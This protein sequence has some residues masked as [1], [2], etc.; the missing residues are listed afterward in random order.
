MAKKKDET[1]RRA[2]PD[3]VMV[4]LAPAGVKHAGE[5]GTLGWA[6][7]RRHFKFV[8]GEAQELER[9]FEW[10]HLLRP[11][12]ISGEPMFEEVP[13]EPEAADAPVDAVGDET[14]KDGE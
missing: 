6:N 1:K 10:N 5:A 3:F 2:R 4:R 11:E 13:D 7:G 8:A 12:T 14:Q 9:S